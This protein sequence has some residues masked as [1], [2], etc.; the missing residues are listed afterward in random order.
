MYYVG[1]SNFV[2]ILHA[3]KVDFKRCLK[4]NS[5]AESRLS[6]NKTNKFTG[7]IFQNRV[8]EVPETEQIIIWCGVIDNYLSKHSKNGQ[9]KL[10]PEQLIS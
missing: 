3:V 4:Q 1:A 6:F 9:T 7:K 5:L 10:N 2:K 8:S